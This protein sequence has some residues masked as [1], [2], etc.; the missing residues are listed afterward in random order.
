MD[1]GGWARRRSPIGIR[2]AAAIACGLLATAAVAAASPIERVLRQPVLT[3][4]WGGLRD[5]LHDRGVD[6]EAVYIGDVFSNL[7]GGLRR[8]T[9]YL[10]N[11]DLTLT[12]HLEDL[13]GI[14]AGSL[15]VY[16]LSNSGGDPSRDVGDAQ[17][18]DNIE[19]PNSIE[20]YEAWW[21]RELLHDRVSLLIGLYDLSSEF[22]VMPSAALFINSS[23][24]T[25]AELGNSGVNGP[26]I[27]PVT[28]LGTR[29]KVDLAE[30][31]LWQTVVLDGIPG[32][33]NDPHGTHIHLG[34][35]DGV[36]IASEAE[37]VWRHGANDDGG[38]AGV[39]RNRR[40]RVS[41]G[42]GALA[43]TLK[44]AAGVWAYTTKQ[45][46]VAPPP[47]GDE[48]GRQRGHPG[49]YVLADYDMTAADSMSSRGPALFARAG[50]ADGDVQQFA[51]YAGA[52]VAYT[53][54]VPRRD[55][56][57]LGFGVAAAFNG[58][59]YERAIRAEGGSPADAEIALEWT[60][61]AVLAP[62]LSV[63]PDLQYIID[64]GARSDRPNAVVLGLRTEISF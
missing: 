39:L 12:C 27:F 34:G 60:Y 20:L 11:L 64:P 42:W 58:S 48:A 30:H 49:V 47:A 59:P 37:V 57:Q 51:A 41:R 61:R 17:I 13:V 7:D 5:A 23:F 45:N 53:G 8:R 55:A 63:Q 19:A 43:H 38:P 3:G 22:D 10:D 28:S 26:S 35:G 15:F 4:N 62:W 46:E 14:D 44:L 52:G 50:I 18:F 31:L 29:L 40:H 16:G 21:Q 25:G 32:D 56:D 36:L 9:R 24:G 6:L 54:L 33:P 2:P 1:G